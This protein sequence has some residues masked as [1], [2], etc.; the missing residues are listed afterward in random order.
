MLILYSIKTLKQH[1]KASG[2][3][4][5]KVSST[6]SSSTNWASSFLKVFNKLRNSSRHPSNIKIYPILIILFLP[7]VLIQSIFSYSGNINFIIKKPKNS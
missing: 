3:E 6:A 2:L 1:A 5:V 7:L 4:L